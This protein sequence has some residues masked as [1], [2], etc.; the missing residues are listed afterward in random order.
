MIKYGGCESAAR[1]MTHY[2]IIRSGY[3]GWIGLSNFTDCI[4]AV[5]TAVAEIAGNCRPGMVNEGISK[6]RCIMT[7]ATIFIAVLVDC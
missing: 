4:D 5:M 3:V 2:A 1:R 7:G 6:S